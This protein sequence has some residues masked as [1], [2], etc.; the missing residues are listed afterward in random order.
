M[1]S[2][3]R[4]RRLAK[5]ERSIALRSQIQQARVQLGYFARNR[6][7]S[8]RTELQEDVAG[9]GRRRLPAFEA[10]AR[11]G[12]PT[13]LSTRSTTGSTEHLGDVATELGLVAPARAGAATPTGHRR[14]AAAIPRHWRP[15]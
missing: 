14:A 2:I 13:M 11:A 15:G 3:A 12:G 1:T 9:I 8:V 10:Y 6:C 5:T 7:N 4:D